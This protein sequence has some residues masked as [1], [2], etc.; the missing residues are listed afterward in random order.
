MPQK[1]SS[2]LFIDLL[3]ALLN[4]IAVSQGADPALADFLEPLASFLGKE[5]AERLELLS[6]HNPLARQLLKAQAT[7]QEC[8]ESRCEYIGVRT[9]LTEYSPLGTELINEA[10]LNLRSQWSENN[11]QAVIYKTIQRDLPSL[12]SDQ[13]NKVADL[14]LDCIRRALLDIPEYGKKIQAFAI[15]RI[16][17]RTARLEEKVDLLIDSNMYSPLQDIDYFWQLESDTGPSILRRYLYLKKAEQIYLDP[18]Q[19]EKFIEK[20]AQD[21]FLLLLG[22]SGSGKTITGLALAEMLCHASSVYQLYYINLRQSGWTTDRLIRG[23]ELRLDHPAIFFLDD[24]QEYFELLQEIEPRLRLAICQKNHSIKFIFTARRILLPIGLDPADDPVFVQDMSERQGVMEFAPTLSSF[25]QMIIH[26]RPDFNFISDKQLNA[27]LDYTGQDMYFLDQLLDVLENV[28]DIDHLSSKTLFRKFLKHHFGTASIKASPSLKYLSTLAQFEITPPCELF[29]PPPETEN[30]LANGLFFTRAGQP[31]CYYFLHSSAARLVFRALLWS[32][33][34]LEEYDQV[35]QIKIIADF[36]QRYFQSIQDKHQLALDLIKVIHAPRLPGQKQDSNNLKTILLAEEYVYQ[37]IVQHFEQFPL[38]TTAVILAIL[39]NTKHPRWIEYHSLVEQKIMDGTILQLIL[40]NDFYT[41][42]YFL[43]HLGWIELDWYRRL[44]EQALQSN[45]MEVISETF[46]E[47]LLWYLSHLSFYKP[48]AWI[49]LIMT[50]PDQDW[51]RLVQRT[52]KSGRSIGTLNLSLR[53]LGRKQPELLK[54][55]EQKIG[56]ERYLKLVE[57]LGSIPELLGIIQFSSPGMRKAIVTAMEGSIVD[58]LVERTIKSGRSIGTLNLSLRDLGRKQPELLK[59]LEQKIGAERYLKLVETLGSIPELFRIIQFSSPGMR[60]AIVTAMEGS[61]VDRLVE[62]TIKF[63]RSIGTLNLPLRD[64]RQE[65]PELL[66][67]LEQKIGAERYLKLV[68]TLGSIPELF[69][70]IQFSSPGMRNAIVTA[71]EGSIVDRLVER[72]IQSGRSIGTVGLSLRDLRQEQ[73]ELLEKLEQK[74]GAERYLK[75]VESL[76]SIPELFKIIEFSSPGMRNAIVTAMEGSIVD[77]LVERTIQSGRSIGTVGL[78]FRDLRQEQPDLL[79]KLEQK[80]GAEYLRK[81]ICALGNLSLLGKIMSECTD[82]FT[83]QLIQ[84]FQLLSECDWQEIILRSSLIDLFYFT[85]YRSKFFTAYPKSYI[86]TVFLP[87]FKTLIQREQW[88]QLCRTWI[89]LRK[90]RKKNSLQSS[91]SL[92]IEEHL[93]TIK[94][95][96]LHFNNFEEAIYALILLWN[97]KRG[98]KTV[99]LEVLFKKLPD[100]ET[101]YECAEFIKL[102]R[103]LFIIFSHPSALVKETRQLLQAGNHVRV[104]PLLRS[105]TTLDDFLYLWNLYALWQQHGQKD[106]K[107][108]SEFLNEDIAQTVKQLTFKRIQSASN[109]EELSYLVAL[110]GFLAY[111]QLGINIK[112]VCD[113]RTL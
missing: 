20:V 85:K 90:E 81:L 113:L 55:L 48:G 41:W 57:T 110:I 23:V 40:G 46:L 51:E 15:F 66:E 49:D 1:R 43:D 91:I 30:P 10:L 26:I 19:T 28:Q 104:I 111:S 7:A 83:V 33:Y 47:N 86:N 42:T 77:R 89:H 98:E 97:A 45:I 79:E 95:G 16:D 9:D 50:V 38:N 60:N 80:I 54:K 99:L 4:G 88:E 5:L 94:I 58:R 61:I 67:K 17:A 21:D 92:I 105:A 13:L 72:T 62:R 75:L 27:L 69:R 76:G 8:F 53:D 109:S 64:L 11:L 102:M 96:E 70:I 101:W 100:Q 36:L 78:S 108:F 44:E 22:S 25:R 84:S 14:F 107:T 29:D 71:M 31:Q 3:F 65:Q 87:I 93:E 106:A 68:E 59:K 63:G 32:E 56:A 2:Y 24:C 12:Q 18:D 34:R 6:K 39:H 35:D 37:Y 52:I 74:I 82:P 112:Q 103:N 73:P